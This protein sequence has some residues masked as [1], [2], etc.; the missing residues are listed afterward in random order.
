VKILFLARHYTYFRNFE[1]LVRGLAQRGH[2]VHLVVERGETLGGLAMVEALA[3]EFPSITY[4]EAPSRA[5]DEWSWIVHRLRLGL[6]YLRYQH[7]VFDT[8]WKLRA[9]SRE[10]TPGVFVR[11]AALVRLL[12]G[13]SRRL[14]TRLLRAMERAVPQDPVIHDYL[15][16]QRADILLL[17]PLVDLA[18]SQIE[19]L[20]AARSLRIPT[21]LCV[22]SWDHLSSKA[23]IRDTPDRVFVWNETQKRE[24]M[25]LHDVPPERVVVTGAQCFDW[26]FDQQPSRDAAA[27]CREAGVQSAPYLLWVCSA[28]IHGSAAEAPFVVKWIETLRRTE[29]TGLRSIPILIRPHP[30]RQSEWDGVDV[31]ALNATVWGGNPVDARSR[32]DY[33]DTL[34]YSA[35]VAGINTSAFIEAAILGRPVYTLVI[36]ET[37]DNQTGTVHFDYLLKAGGGLLEVATSF[38]EHVAQLDAAL[39]ASKRSVKPFVREFVRPHGLDTSATSQFIAGVEAMHGLRVAAPHTDPL[40]GVWRWAA[41]RAARLRDD[42]GYEQW[43]LSA[44][45]LASLEKLRGARRLKALQRAESRR[46][47]KVDTPGT[48]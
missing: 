14:L 19:Y 25:T 28:L 4:G 6:D 2:L 15:A 23:L 38:D 17:T 12:G 40:A 34:Y 8:A 9:R 32:A 39:A 48:R 10:R 11:M 43:T 37:A 29:S 27:F 7:P 47:Q 16:A 42:E 5:P 1:S 20:R 31:S 3:G 22:W 21:G 33:F 24:A 26:W 44:R 46:A 41:S 13:W 30:S 45:E 18:S 36:P 35:A